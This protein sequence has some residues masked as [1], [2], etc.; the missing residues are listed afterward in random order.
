MYILV[1][2]GDYVLCCYPQPVVV[3][4]AYAFGININTPQCSQPLVGTASCMAN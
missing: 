3:Q 4:S 1:I 2:M